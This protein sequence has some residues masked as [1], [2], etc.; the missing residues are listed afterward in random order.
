L[1]LGTSPLILSFST[2]ICYGSLP[3]NDMS[4]AFAGMTKKG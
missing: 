1:A 2:L 3:Q 4:W